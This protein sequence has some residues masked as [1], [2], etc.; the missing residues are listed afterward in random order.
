MGFWCVRFTPQLWT[1]ELTCDTRLVRRRNG[2]CWKHHDAR[3]SDVRRNACGAV[4]DFGRV[5]CIP[6]GPVAG[7]LIQLPTNSD[8]TSCLVYVFYMQAR[9]SWIHKRSC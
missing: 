2:L 9:L 4:R 6:L 5:S 8:L 1:I 7:Q 3:P